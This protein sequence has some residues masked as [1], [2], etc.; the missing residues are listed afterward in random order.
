MFG[1]SFG[2]YQAGLSNNNGLISDTYSWSGPCVATSFKNVSYFKPAQSCDAS[3]ATL[4]SLNRSS[5]SFISASGGTANFFV[6]PHLKADITYESHAA[7]IERQL[8][9]NVALTLSY[10]PTSGL[11]FAVLIV[12][13][14][15]EHRDTRRHRSQPDVKQYSATL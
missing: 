1:D 14:R 11:Q 10:I 7:K 3:P 2:P 9:P 13:T 8:V 12:G 15:R 4:A 5:P 6:N